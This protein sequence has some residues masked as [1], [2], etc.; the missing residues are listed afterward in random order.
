MTTTLA[1]TL[2]EW[3]LTVDI[4]GNIALKSGAQ[5]LAQDVGSAVKT[6]LGELYYDTSLGMPWPTILGASYSQGYLEV[7]ITKAALAVAGVAKAQTTI[8]SFVNR[9]AHGHVYVT[10]DADVT[11]PVE[12]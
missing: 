6:F 3:D 7:Q 11:F 9:E 8:T 1:L 2:A 10:S 4:H 5:E 12:F